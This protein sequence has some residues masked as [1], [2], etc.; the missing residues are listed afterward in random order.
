MKKYLLGLMAVAGLATAG[1]ALPTA[2]NAQDWHHDGGR[3]DWHRD[4]GHGNWNGGYR[5]GGHRWNNNG[6]RVGY[7][8]PA[9]YPAYRPAYYRPVYRP[10]A[11]YPEPYYY[12]P[13]LALSFNIR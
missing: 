13:G 4:G 9:Y 12:N 8:Q 7:Y 10:V 5:D 11:Y 3:G 1:M 2:A 6:V